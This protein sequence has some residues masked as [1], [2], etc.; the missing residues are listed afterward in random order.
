MTRDIIKDVKNLY[1][2]IVCINFEM[3]ILETNKNVTDSNLV[4]IWI[5][6]DNNFDQK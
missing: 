5:H 6:L 3:T 4:E 1:L 2:K